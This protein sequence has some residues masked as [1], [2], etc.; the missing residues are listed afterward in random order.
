MFEHLHFLRPAALLLAPLLGGLWWLWQRQSDPLR[1]WRGQVDPELLRALVDRGDGR[2]RRPWLVL[3][4]WL[5][6]VVALVVSRR[7][8]PA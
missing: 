5:L 7:R 2:R 4:A 6:A 3:V 8:R 1:G